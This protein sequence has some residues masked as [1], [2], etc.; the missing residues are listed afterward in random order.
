MVPNVFFL[1]GYVITGKTVLE[2]Y[3]SPIPKA[4]PIPLL[5]CSRPHEAV[6][7][8]RCPVLL[9]SQVLGKLCRTFAQSWQCS[10][11]RPC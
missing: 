11:R 1:E 3:H 2:A 10:W 8:A 9:F 6:Y 5:L 7:E 4:F